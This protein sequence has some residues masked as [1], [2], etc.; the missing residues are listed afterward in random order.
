MSRN[1]I[2]KYQYSSFLKNV[3]L[4]VSLKVCHVYVCLFESYPPILTITGCV[5]NFCYGEPYG[6]G[7]CTTD[8]TGQPAVCCQ[9]ADAAACLASFQKG[10][11]G[12]TPDAC[13]T[14]QAEVV[15][16]DSAVAGFATMGATDQAK[17]LCYDQKGNYD[18]SYWDDS[19]ASCYS[20]GSAAHPKIWALLTANDDLALGFCTKFAG[21]VSSVATTTAPADSASATPDVTSS[22]AAVAS[23][24]NGP[25]SVQSTSSGAL[26]GFSSIATIASATT[27]SQAATTPATTTKTSKAA[28]VNVDRKM[29]VIGLR[30]LLPSLLMAML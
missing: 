17:C 1:E 4:Q 21:P 2:I 7:S 19:A 30:L 14:I 15:Y 6:F 5:N 27:A 24:S 12:G 23:N 18:P 3:L 25:A 10:L 20:S 26:P 8:F 29:L 9:Q 22:N 13:S 11:G 28:K 16:C